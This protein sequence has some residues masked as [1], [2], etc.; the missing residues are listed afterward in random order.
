MQSVQHESCSFISLEYAYEFSAHVVKYN[1]IYGL[2]STNTPVL[3]IL[4]CGY[5]FIWILDDF[6]NVIELA[7]D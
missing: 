4:F 5:H 7:T 2:F 3:E 6:G 1:V